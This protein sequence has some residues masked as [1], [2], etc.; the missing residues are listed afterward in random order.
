[1]PNLLSW[2]LS[3]WTSPASVARSAV[4]ELIGPSGEARDGGVD[5]LHH[6]HGRQVLNLSERTIKGHL[7]TALNKLGADNRAQAAVLAT[8]RGLV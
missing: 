5:P 4:R 1:M 2:A 7:T 6:L 8:Q 3:S